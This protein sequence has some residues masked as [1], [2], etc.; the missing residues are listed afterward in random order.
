VVLACLHGLR[1][2]GVTGYVYHSVPVAIHA[3]LT[4]PRDL[5]SAV[6]SVIRCGGD[7]DSTGAIVGGILG[8][9]VGRDGV[10][11]DWLLALMEWPRS[12]A[13]MERLGG[14]LGTV[15]RSGESQRP[16][17]LSVPGIWLR[18]LLFLGVVLFHGFR[19]LFPPY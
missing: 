15:V 5:R 2:K 7:T 16:T 14:Q 9:A 19:R 1:Y 6:M 10:P 18:N 8:A 13:W 4:H 11:S 3:W 17:G 12:V